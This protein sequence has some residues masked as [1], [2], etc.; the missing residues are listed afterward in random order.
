MLNLTIAFFH[1]TFL[2]YSITRGKLSLFPILIFFFLF[3]NLYLKSLSARSGVSISFLLAPLIASLG[4]CMATSSI[5][6][7]EKVGLVTQTEGFVFYT[8]LL[9]LPSTGKTPAINIFQRAFRLKDQIQDR[10][11]TIGYCMYNSINSIIVNSMQKTFN[12]IKVQYKR[13]TKY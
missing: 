5:I 10:D 9:G 6:L 2:T 4:H 13:V 7:E 3:T 11:S 1:Q 8:V 12:N